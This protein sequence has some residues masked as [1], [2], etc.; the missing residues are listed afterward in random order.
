MSYTT[1]IRWTALTLV[2][3][4]VSSFGACIE[5]NRHADDAMVAK[6]QADAM[7]VQAKAQADAVA[8]ERKVDEARAEAETARAQADKAMWDHMPMPAK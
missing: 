6:A 8:A 4:I 3:L 5:V 1:L 2:T 7:A